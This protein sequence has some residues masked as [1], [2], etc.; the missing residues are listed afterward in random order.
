VVALDKPEIHK[1]KSACTVLQALFNLWCLLVQGGCPLFQ[2]YQGSRSYDRRIQCQDRRRL[3]GQNG[4][5]HNKR[6]L[7]KREGY[8]NGYSALKQLGPPID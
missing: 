5:H 7:L 1:Q 3:G 2:S 6:R 8:K 4:E